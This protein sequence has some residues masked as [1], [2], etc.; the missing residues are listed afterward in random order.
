MPSRE[1]AQVIGPENCNSVSEPIA[2]VIILA[3]GRSSRMGYDKAQV[4][5]DG[6]RLIDLCLESIASV[7]AHPIVVSGQD[8]QLTAAVTQVMEEPAF[9]GP[10]AGIAAG[11]RCCDTKAGLIGVIAVDAPRSGNYLNQLRRVVLTHPEVGVAHAVVEGYDQP[12]L[13][14]WRY[15]ALTQALHA[16]G[17]PRNVAAKRLLRSATTPV[18]AVPVDS[19]ARDYDTVAELSALGRVR[20]R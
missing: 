13:A 4:M 3:G 2:Y 9:G 16:L 14:V 6:R 19:S 5:V 10:V 11:M 18:I 15:E 17:S 7:H 1:A 8:L 20:L 12:L